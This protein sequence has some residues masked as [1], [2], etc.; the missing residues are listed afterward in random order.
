MSLIKRYDPALMSGKVFICIFDLNR[1][2]LNMKECSASPK[3]NVYVMKYLI[4]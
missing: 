3:I 2:W 4:N 1:V